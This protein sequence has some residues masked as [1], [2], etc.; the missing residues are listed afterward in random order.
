MAR[1]ST[2]KCEPVSIQSPISQENGMGHTGDS[3]SELSQVISELESLVTSRADR[4]AAIGSMDKALACLLTTPKLRKIFEDELP[5]NTKLA[6]LAPGVARKFLDRIIAQIADVPRWEALAASDP[7]QYRSQLTAV[8][9]QYKK[10][11]NVTCGIK[12]HRPRKEAQNLAIWEIKSSKPAWS[13][14]QV[15]R[16]YMRRTG[17]PMTARIAERTYTRAKPNADFLLDYP[18][19]LLP[20]LK[21]LHDTTKA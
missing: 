8:L 13:F 11:L 10:L 14:G 7:K 4:K 20:L 17:K 2:A 6:D 21:R 3:E 16:E 15:A 19:T 9:S 5:E 1:G 12:S 18:T